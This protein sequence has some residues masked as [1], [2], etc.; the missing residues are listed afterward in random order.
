MTSNKFIIRTNMRALSKVLFILFACTILLPTRAHA[1][2]NNFT[3]TDYR[4]EYHLSRDQAQHSILKTTET[5]TADFRIPN[6]NHGIE[7]A[8]P[9]DYDGHPTNVKILSVQDESGNNRQYRTYA[10]NGNLVVRI[11]DPDTYVL[12]KQ[13]YV[14]TY[15]QQDVTKYFADANRDEFYWDTN[16]TGWQVP[17]EQL[18]VSLTID[19]A[20]TN[21]LTGNIA[22]YQGAQRSTQ[23][24]EIIRNNNQFTTTAANLNIHENLTIAIGFQPKTFT[25]YEIP[26]WQ[27]FL[28]GWFALQTLLLFISIGIIIWL[29]SRYNTWKNRKNEPTTIVPEYLPPKDISVTT[30]AMLLGSK[31][32]VAAQIID[33]AVRHYLKIYQVREKSIFKPA[34]YKIEL[35]KDPSTLLTEEQELLND[36]YRQTPQVGNYLYLSTLQQSSAVRA[37]LSDNDK[38]FQNLIRNEYGLR[39]KDPEKSAWF[40]RVGRTL[41]VLSMP[42]L[43]PVLLIASTIA[44]MLGKSL[45]PLTD[46][47]L[48]LMRY[49]EGLKLYISVAE[50]ER[51][52]LLQSPEGAAKVGIS[53]Q[54]DNVQLIQLYER[55]LPYAILF[56]Q[57]KE[58]N[59]RLARYYEANN[60]TSDWLVTRDGTLFSSAAFAKAISDISTTQYGSPSSSSTSGSGG[61]GFSGGGGG[62]G[63]GGGW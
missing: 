58:W 6:Q 31:K 60:Y 59:K 56:G 17:I 25:A 11:G 57:E 42:L 2:V 43:S 45:W 3:I 36:I 44:Y 16:G 5:I 48:E 37:Q 52:Q 9:T 33:L 39:H 23:T 62:G 55:V 29:T 15:S 49:L 26:S 41:L 47:G 27:K 63:G 54:P 61:G 46:K 13:T 40:K 34:E 7:R 24:C 10:S 12:G 28:F 8:I 19:D 30:A 18:S 51:L 14:I 22:C 38:K 20:L 32:G 4:I 50:Q 21:R 35:T 1:Q 53:G